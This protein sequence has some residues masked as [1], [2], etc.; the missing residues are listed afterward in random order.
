MSNQDVV[1]IKSCINL[2][3]ELADELNDV[4][5]VSGM[6]QEELITHYVSEGVSNAMPKVKRKLFFNH[7]K[8]ILKKHNIPNDA[9]DEIV[10]KFTY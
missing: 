1:S 3:V 9:I 7:T 4:A 5:R 2:P 8:E 6:T 10:K